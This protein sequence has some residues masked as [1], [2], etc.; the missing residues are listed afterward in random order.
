MAELT[1]KQILE[2][3]DRLAHVRDYRPPVHHYAF[4][5]PRLLQL[6]REV[7]AARGVTTGGAQQENGE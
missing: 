2:L 4:S 7:L 3:A 5:A 1:D 6:V